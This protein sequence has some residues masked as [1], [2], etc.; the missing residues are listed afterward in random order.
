MASWRS[1]C[2]APSATSRA[3]SRCPD[4]RQPFP[5]GDPVMADQALQVQE[6]KELT[7]KGEKTTPARY[8]IPDTDIH[9]TEEALVL[10]MEVPGVDRGNVD[11][12]I[13]DDVLR[14]EARVDYSKYEGMEPLYTEY[15]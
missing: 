7:A 15:N 4:R 8:Y 12:K 13:E 1:T 6:K 3:R 10:A 14:V 2:R 9:E 5:G 11:V